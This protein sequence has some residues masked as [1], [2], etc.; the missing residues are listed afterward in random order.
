MIKEEEEELENSIEVFN[1]NRDA[2]LTDSVNQSWNFEEEEIGEAIIN[3]RASA[4]NSR[5]LAQSKELRFNI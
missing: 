1:Y 2:D 5:F 4:P 3:Q